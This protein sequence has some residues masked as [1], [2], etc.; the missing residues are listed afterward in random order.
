MSRAPPIIQNV[1]NNGNKRA[2]ATLSVPQVQRGPPSIPIVDLSN[3]AAKTS[4]QPVPKPNNNNNQAVAILQAAS[5]QLPSELTAQIMPLLNKGGHLV[6]A[7][8]ADF[9]RA[10]RDKRR[11]AEF[12]A[13]EAKAWA[14]EAKAIAEAS[15]GHL[16][17]AS[18]GAQAPVIRRRPVIP[19]DD[20]PEPEPQV[21]LL[22][23]NPPQLE[24]STQ[25]AQEYYRRVGEPIELMN[26]NPEEV[27]RVL[28]DDYFDPD[29]PN[30]PNFQRGGI[31]IEVDNGD[32]KE[33]STTTQEF[34]EPMGSY[35]L[36]QT[37]QEQEEVV[38]DNIVQQD[39]DDRAEEAQNRRIDD[40]VASEA[41]RLL[42]SMH[43]VGIPDMPP[44]SNPFNYPAAPPAPPAPVVNPVPVSAPLPPEE[45][46]QQPEVALQAYHPGLTDDLKARV[47]A[48]KAEA[49][50]KLEEK[51]K[52]QEYLATVS[53][54]ER[55]ESESEFYYKKT[56]PIQLKFTRKQI[57]MGMYTGAITRTMQ[58]PGSSSTVGDFPLRL[59]ICQV[60]SC[61]TGPFGS[62]YDHA[63]M[64]K[65]FAQSEGKMEGYYNRD[66]AT[67]EYK[68]SNVGKFGVAGN[69]KINRVVRT[70]DKN[71]KAILS[72]AIE[73]T[74]I[75]MK[76]VEVFVW[77]RKAEYK[78]IRTDMYSNDMGSL[79]NDAL[80]NARN[81]TLR[82]NQLDEARVK[83][84]NEQEKELFE[85]K[86]A[87]E[88][89]TS[90]MFQSVVIGIDDEIRKSTYWTMDPE[91]LSND[92]YYIS[93]STKVVRPVNQGEIMSDEIANDSIR[94][95]LWVCGYVY[96]GPIIA[97]SSGQIL[98]PFNFETQLKWKDWASPRILVK[99]NPQKKKKIGM[100]LNIDSI[101]IDEKIIFEYIKPID[102]V[103]KI[104]EGNTKGLYLEYQ[105][106]AEFTLEWYDKKLILAHDEAVKMNNEKE[107]QQL[108]NNNANPVA[109]GN[110]NLNRPLLMPSQP[111][112]APQLQQIW[113]NP[114]Q[115]QPQSAYVETVPRRN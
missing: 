79:F 63:H 110:P 20:E 78:W 68:F 105:S 101:V 67:L 83:T 92:I 59:P 102:E 103:K 108:N 107:Q 99:P 115:P 46:K 18:R 22:E 24:Y 44:P 58:R 41:D 14:D 109:A 3:K 38:A 93:A 36:V 11:A 53:F 86:V 89:L 8:A 91:V 2:A 34:N 77:L 30:N 85:H 95:A 80:S 16:I 37:Q 88:C 98:D 52:K 15:T 97:T 65:W 112:S 61:P 113:S 33:N 31:T 13:A 5:R 55:I 21:V 32:Q 104:T 12:K 57:E 76:M 70:I 27:R 72:S 4:I 7:T 111:Q 50:K 90:P 71:T 26:H 60:M 49:L 87:M 54:D 39:I 45:K 96:H 74:E 43:D 40:H 75:N 69:K 84:F 81:M 62:F 66:K 28:Q 23:E 10:E 100:T 1:N 48:K 114:N 51:K 106:R 17:A 73:E 9:A 82:L 42:D 64:K 47:E 25:Q 29:N 56:D 35:E 6:P 94:R 19:D